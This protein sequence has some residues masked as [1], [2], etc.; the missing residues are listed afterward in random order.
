MIGVPTGARLASACEQRLGRIVL[1]A[2]MLDLVRVSSPWGTFKPSKP[3]RIVVAL[4]D[5]SLYL[6]ELRS[7]AVSFSVGTVLCR[8]PRYGLVAQWRHRWWAWP[9]VWKAE[10]CW[11]G[12]FTFVEGAL[13]AGADADRLMGLLVADD[14]HR[15]MG[16]A[17]PA[18][19]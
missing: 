10:L 14:F 15:E 9:A 2:S 18:L 1:G 19:G 12:A 6:V 13:M 16:L 4:T 5:D 17:A 7:G 8:F 11:P 3:L